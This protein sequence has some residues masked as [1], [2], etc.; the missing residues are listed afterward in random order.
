MVFRWNPWIPHLL[1]QESVKT[2]SDYSTLPQA[3]FDL[4]FVLL[5]AYVGLHIEKTI[6]CGE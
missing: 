3:E 4:K 6:A 1:P 2:V 5:K